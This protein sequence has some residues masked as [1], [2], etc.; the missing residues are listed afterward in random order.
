MPDL[1]VLF[2]D[3]KGRLWVGQKGLYVLHPAR[4][5]FSLYPDRAGLSSEF[6]KGI[7]EDEEGY[8]W[9]AT[10]NRI[11]QFNPDT[12]A[13]NKYNTGDG[14]QGLELEAHAYLQTKDGEM[15]F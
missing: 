5:M 2:T 4:N 3:S 1:R 14:V 10:S 13:F 15:K 9:I 12:Y 11:T 8:L 6:I 7:T